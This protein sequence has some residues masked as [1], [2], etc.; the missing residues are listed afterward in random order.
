MNNPDHKAPSTLESN[1]QTIENEKI[2]YINEDQKMK[3]R[4]F[5]LQPRKQQGPGELGTGVYIN[6]TLLSPDDKL[7][8]DEY[9]K[10]HHLNIYASDLIS[11]HRT[12]NQDII[13]PR[14]KTIKY[15]DLDSCSIIIAFRNEAWS[16][17][18][19]TI[20]SVLDHTPESLIDEI[21]LVDDGS[22]ENYL[23]Y[24]LDVYISY[25]SKVRIIRLPT[26]MGLFVAK[27]TALD[28]V[29]SKHFAV[30]DSHS[31]VS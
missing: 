19:R 2:V 17:L 9:Y 20:H 12:L 25:L 7:K 1:I 24:K 27:Q 29:K 23:K 3:S 21:L 11:V 4:I 10:K 18:V 22:T 15:E 28:Q 30:L 16:T 6:R 14:C 13:D 26:S 8:Y 5:L 31:E